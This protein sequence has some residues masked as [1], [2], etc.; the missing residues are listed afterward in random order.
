MA[1]KFSDKIDDYFDEYLTLMLDFPEKDTFEIKHRRRILR[2]WLN[3][4]LTEWENTKEI[5]VTQ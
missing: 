4:E 2:E 3:N 5:H 1:Y